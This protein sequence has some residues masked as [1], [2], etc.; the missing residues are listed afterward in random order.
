MTTQAE[1]LILKSKFHDTLLYQHHPP[2]VL[3]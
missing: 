2:S 1:E 3:L